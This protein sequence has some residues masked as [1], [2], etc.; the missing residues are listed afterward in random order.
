MKLFF[1]MFVF[2]LLL[3][4][5]G[6]SQN[7]SKNDLFVGLN[8]N[9]NNS[10]LVDIY[11]SPLV[12]YMVNDNLMVSGSAIF[13]S[14][15]GSKYS[16]VSLGLRY[17][18]TKINIKPSVNTF[19]ELSGGKSTNEYDNYWGFGLGVS[20]FLTKHIYLEPKL[21][22]QSTYLNTDRYLSTGLQLGAGLK[23]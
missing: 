9:L 12:G 11:L 18:N 6:T 14:S 1:R 7:V 17:Y 22:L 10:R 3:P 16:W 2:V 15:N 19:L 5:I 21:F 20:A 13:N 23:F 8:T 4:I